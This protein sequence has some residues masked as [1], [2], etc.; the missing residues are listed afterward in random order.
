MTNTLLIE[1]LSRTTHVP[2][3]ECTL[4]TEETNLS[5]LHQ[6][7]WCRVEI[8]LVQLTEC[9]VL[10]LIISL[11]FTWMCTGTDTTDTAIC[12]CCLACL[13]VLNN[14]IV[15]LKEIF[16]PRVIEGLQCDFHCC[17]HTSIT[18]IL[19]A[20]QWITKAHHTWTD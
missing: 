16:Q 12:R 3:T 18:P 15:L 1:V 13:I 17:T 11:T 2:T 5:I 10:V 20:W 8:L 9:D 4:C 7:K 14:V 19:N 6:I